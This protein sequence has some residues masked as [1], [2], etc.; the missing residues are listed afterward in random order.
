MAI[1]TNYPLDVTLGGKTTQIKEYITRQPVQL[2]KIATLARNIA[3]AENQMS[4]LEDSM[5]SLINIYSGREPEKL[6]P[7]H[8]SEDSL[9]PRIWVKTEAKNKVKDLIA[10]YTPMFR[11]NQTGN[12]KELTGLSDYEKAAYK[13]MTINIL[14][15][16]MKDVDVKFLNLGWPIYFDI[17]PNQGELLTAYDS[18]KQNLLLAAPRKLQRYAFFYDVSWPVLV[19][20]RAK[21]EFYGEGYSF[22]IALEGNIKDNKNLREFLAG[23]GS[24]GVYQPLYQMGF[25]DKALKDEKVAKAANIS[26]ARPPELFCSLKQMIGT[27]FTLNITSSDKDTSIEKAYVTFGC[28][29]Y[30]SCDIGTAKKDPKTNTTS[31]QFKAPVCLNGG[32][33]KIEAPEHKTKYI[34]KLS[35]TPGDNQQIGVELRKMWKVNITIKKLP[36]SRNILYRDP[37]SDYK[38]NYVTN[39]TPG[40]KTDID[41][42][43]MAIL[44]IQRQQDEEELF[45]D[46]PQIVIID[47]EKGMYLSDIEIIP[48]KYSISGTLFDKNGVTIEPEERCYYKNAVGKCK[49]KVSV[50]E[51]PVNLPLFLSGG[52]Q[53]TE[54]TGLWEVKP[55]DLIN[56]KTLEVTLI[57]VPK[58]LIVEDLEESSHIENYTMKYQTRIKPRLV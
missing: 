38:G 43:D 46:T 34:P 57:Q 7:F 29:P 1:K 44:N 24:V 51:S 47:P 28:G 33:I 10:T 49:A 50:P 55:Q 20:I 30:A 56:K 36:L 8:F 14:Q 41:Q 13:M 21:D 40:E 54:E 22:A 15:K 25:D 53:I 9:V 11:V 35:S 17:T 23:A 58:P 3:L 4:Y 5:I 45:P 6:P 48:G 39:L 37:V 2:K 26:A 19:E 12:Y 18:W 32:Y 31:I 27:N 42:T 16:P 52:I